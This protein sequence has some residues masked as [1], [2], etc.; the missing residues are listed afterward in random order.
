MRSRKLK[1][2]VDDLLIASAFI[3][4][5]IWSVR[6]T[7]RGEP[8]E[9][10]TEWYRPVENPVFTTTMGNNHD[11]I[12]FVEPELEY[13]YHLIISHTPEAAH[14]WRARTFS[15]SSSDWEL[16]SSQYEIGG[17]Y[18]YDDG[19]K[20]DDTYYI[21]EAGKVYTF[22]GPLELASGNWTR[23]GTF[24]EGTDDVG[25]FYED[26][27]F[28]IFGE[29]G[30]FPWRPDGVSLAHYTSRTGLGDW[31]LVDANAVD[32]NP[33]MLRIYGVGDATIAK[34]E[35]AYYIF[36]DRESRWNPYTV[37]AWRSDDLDSPFEYLGTAIRPRSNRTEDWDNHRIQDA[38]IGYI[39]ELSRYVIFCNMKDVDG[40]PGGDFPNLESTE[41][42]VV[43]VFYSSSLSDEK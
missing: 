5:S 29:Y 36:C 6:C 8:G 21:Y 25:V 14:L 3:L 1:R 43:G 31:E 23:S 28:H 13:S 2:R 12:L 11:P 18:E 33:G 10:W 9:E 15:W 20:V 35:G 4:I 39:P 16:V 38:D 34:I 17:H 24:P 30:R 7:G 19:V 27:V 42:R 37:T 41:T 32:P 26:G 40:I 22:S